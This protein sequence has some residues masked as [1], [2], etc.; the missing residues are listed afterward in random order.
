MQ[1]YQTFFLFGGF[2]KRRLC[3]PEAEGAKGLEIFDQKPA[4]KDISFHILLFVLVSIW[5]L[6]LFFLFK[7]QNKTS[8]PKLR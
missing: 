8:S 1:P 3:Q 6:H 4:N 5:R 7:K 2:L